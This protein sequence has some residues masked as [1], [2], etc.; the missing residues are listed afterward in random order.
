MIQKPSKLNPKSSQRGS[1][2]RHGSSGDVAG[3]SGWCLGAVL[4]G[5][6]EFLLGGFGEHLERLFGMLSRYPFRNRPG[7]DF[8]PN[9]K[10]F[11]WMFSVI[12]E[13]RKDMHA[14]MSKPPKSC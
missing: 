5:S 14:R 9:L 2:R 4:G 10:V 6:G 8:E 12:F 1:G 3:A 7:F 13:D 11:G